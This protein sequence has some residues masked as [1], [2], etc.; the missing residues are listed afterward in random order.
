MHR[1]ALSVF[2][3]AYLHELHGVLCRQVSLEHRR[4]QLQLVLKLPEQ[5]DIV[6]GRLKLHLIWLPW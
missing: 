3:L 6:G 5:P 4:H 2:E 1:G